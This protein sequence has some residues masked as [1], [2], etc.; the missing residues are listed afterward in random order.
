MAKA[1]DDSA[2]ADDEDDESVQ[3]WPQLPQLELEVCLA[4]LPTRPTRGGVR[5]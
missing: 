2:D 3:E 4:P 5:R 1:P